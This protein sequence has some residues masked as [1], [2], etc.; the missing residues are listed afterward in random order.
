MIELL[1]NIQKWM[2]H[3]LYFHNKRLLYK[4][5]IKKSKQEELSLYFLFIYVQ[6]FLAFR[7]A[8][9]LLLISETTTKGGRSSS[10]WRLHVTSFLRY[11]NIRLILS[12]YV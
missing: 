9:L 2:F 12:S 3:A 7:D 6:E 8:W 4:K 11:S 5:E 10:V 1:T